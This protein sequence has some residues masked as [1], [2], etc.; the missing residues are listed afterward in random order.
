M[1]PPAVPP[2]GFSSAKMPGAPNSEELF[3][4][5]VLNLSEFCVIAAK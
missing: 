1:L 4:K 5:Q 3:A 2:W